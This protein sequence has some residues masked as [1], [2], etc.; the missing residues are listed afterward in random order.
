MDKRQAGSIGGRATFAKHGREHMQDIGARGA[1]VTWTRYKLVPIRQTEY[2]L[3]ERATGK[4]I[5]VV[6]R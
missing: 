6:S 5:R 4:I 3:T 2:A 1:M